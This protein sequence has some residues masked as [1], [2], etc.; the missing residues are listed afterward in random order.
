MK[1]TILEALKDPGVR[2]VTPAAQNVSTV[3]SNALSPVSAIDPQRTAEHLRQELQDA[4]DS[5]GVM[6]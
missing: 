3:L 2:P 1:E 4:L 6:P 5:K